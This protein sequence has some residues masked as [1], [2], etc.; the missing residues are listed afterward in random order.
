MRTNKQ[1][2]AEDE[3]VR[4]RLSELN[5]RYASVPKAPAPHPDIGDW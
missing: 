1:V 3:G 2:A 5:A 4:A